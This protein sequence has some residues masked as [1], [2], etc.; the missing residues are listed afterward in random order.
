VGG[1]E[2]FGCCLDAGWVV[3]REGEVL[4]GRALHVVELPDGGAEFLL[5][6]ADAGLGWETLVFIPCWSWLLEDMVFTM[7]KGY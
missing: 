5:Q 2:E 1:A 4:M 7:G 3:V 6:V